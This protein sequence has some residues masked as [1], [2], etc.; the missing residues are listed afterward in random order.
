MR[1]KPWAP[2]RQN[3]D[4]NNTP[5]QGFLWQPRAEALMAAPC[6]A[7]LAKPVSYLHYSTSFGNF[8]PEFHLCK[9][10]THSKCLNWSVSGWIVFFLGAALCTDSLFRQLLRVL[11]DRNLDWSLTWP[12]PRV[13]GWMC[14][15]FC[16]HTWVMTLWQSCEL[17][18]QGFV[19]GFNTT[20]GGCWEDSKMERKV[21]ASAGKTY[22][23]PIGVKETNIGW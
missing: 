13:T 3:A 17:S 22:V 7:S 1:D 21:F 10:K 8:H 2:L 20:Q 19:P 15:S 23:Q 14:W 12:F 5:P 16:W 4:Q 9:R 11:S 18:F 6:K